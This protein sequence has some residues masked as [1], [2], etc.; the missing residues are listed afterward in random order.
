MI[1]ECYINIFKKNNIYI[2][3]VCIMELLKDIIEV[4]Q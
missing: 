4:I 2:Y 3:I 1:F